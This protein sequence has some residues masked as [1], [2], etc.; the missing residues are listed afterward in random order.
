M[1]KVKICG[2][3]DTETAAFAVE[4]G[5]DAIGFVFAE[6]KRKVTPDTAAAII[7]QLP[8][9][10]LK[11]GVFVNE[12]KETIE[13]II[14]ATG[15]NIVQ[16]HGEESPEF[17]EGFS[18]PVIKAF[19]ISTAADLE[20]LQA[21]ES[22]GYYLLDSPKG[23]YHGGNG[24]AFDWSVLKYTNLNKSKLILAGGLTAENVAEGIDQAEPFMVDVSSGVETEGKKDKQ[25]IKRFIQNAK[26]AL[27]EEMK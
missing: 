27:K 11:V 7:Q 9:S 24:I 14:T 23:K 12:S 19:S 2:I 5:A 4:R 10:L 15:I 25:K 8:H 26:A 21:Y 17:C 1:M 13:E 20:R 22:C 6:S 18:V 3:T 16:L